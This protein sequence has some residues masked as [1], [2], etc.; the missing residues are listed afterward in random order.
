[1]LE[2]LLLRKELPGNSPH[3]WRVSPYRDTEK[4]LQYRIFPMENLPK[5][6]NSPEDPSPTEIFSRAIPR[7]ISMC[8]TE[9]PKRK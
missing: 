4:I 9:L 1:M 5:W 8:K 3:P 7:N 2:I 6:N